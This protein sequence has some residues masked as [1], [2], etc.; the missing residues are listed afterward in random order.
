MALLFFQ[1]ANDKKREN[2]FLCFYQMCLSDLKASLTGPPLAKAARGDEKVIMF[3]V[4]IPSLPNGQSSCSFSNLSTQGCSIYVITNRLRQTIFPQP[5][6][7]SYFFKG[8][9]ENIVTKLE[10]VTIFQ[11]MEKCSKC[12]W[13]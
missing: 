1:I 5:M 12:T 4:I 11:S 7:H 8:G 3:D 9:S 2:T 6:S 10:I 13:I